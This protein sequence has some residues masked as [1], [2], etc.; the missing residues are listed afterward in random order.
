MLSSV[1]YRRPIVG[2]RM[3]AHGS[4]G[5]R[6][7]WAP[8]ARLVQPSS[9]SVLVSSP[10]NRRRSKRCAVL[11]ATRSRGDPGFAHVFEETCKHARIVRDTDD[12]RLF[13]APN[14]D[15]LARHPTRC[16]SRLHQNTLH[17]ASLA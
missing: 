9:P 1:T 4:I 14:G 2:A 13:A 7:A 10:Q 8:G 16:D 5:R 11:Q 15:L 17:T 12:H 6:S 3:S